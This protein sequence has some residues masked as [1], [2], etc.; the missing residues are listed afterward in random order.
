MDRIKIL[1]AAAEAVPFIKTGGLADVVG[2][3]PYALDPERF[4]V[5]V[6]LP[7]YTCIAPHLRAQMKDVL[8]TTLFFNG[9]DRYLGLR[10][11]E[12][13]GI[14]FYFL[15]NE[16][17][18][19][20]PGPYT[21][22]TFDIEKFAF[23]SR[24][25][26]A[27]LPMIDFRPD[28][29][30]CHD[31]HSGLIPPYLKT[32]LHVAPF[33]QNIKTVFTIHNLKFQGLCG[34]EYLCQI[35]GLPWHLFYE[36]SLC[37]GSGG[38][39]MKGAI[40][41]ADKITTVSGSYAEEIKTPYYGETMDGMLQWRGNDF[42]GIV[43]GIDTNLF[44]PAK[45]EALPE[46]YSLDTLAKGKDIAKAAL[47]KEMGL[48]QEKDAF[49]LGMVTRLTEQKGLD[50]LLP[51]LGKLCE[52]PFQLAIIGSGDYFYEHS[53][54][55]CAAAHPRRMSVFLGYSDPLARRIYAGCDAFLMPSRFEPCGLSQLIALRYGTPPI[56]RATGGLKDTVASLD[57]AG[58]E[59]T[60]FAFENYD[61]TGFN[62]AIDYALDTYQHH[63]RTWKKLR[64]NA[65][66]QDFSW[67]RSAKEYEALY[68]SLL[69]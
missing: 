25:L 29:I 9:A 67:S 20:G 1:L 59:A 32:V 16:S 2:A 66:K 35:S 52:A 13:E 38:N 28:V 21:D 54:W 24:G 14:T 57:K 33:Y 65:M 64:E 47:Q 23:F 18:F 56:V 46:K 10:A 7:A 63:P 53:L 39:M 42:S 60:G 40:Q 12:R 36:G 6:M 4:D 26:L 49:L 41:F 22:Y 69:P 45:D 3:L 62:W 11:L 31:W 30:H 51:L 68:Q 19:S 50:L 58:D 8:N 17:Y 48:A 55:E 37:S 15:D 34:R 43:N 61:A 5:R 27:L 44:D